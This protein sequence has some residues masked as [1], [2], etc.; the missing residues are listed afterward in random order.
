M[1]RRHK[2]SEMIIKAR[3]SAYQHSIV[4]HDIVTY[5]LVQWRS[6][7]NTCVGDGTIAHHLKGYIVRI[8]SRTIRHDHAQTEEDEWEKHDQQYAPGQ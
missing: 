4:E 1:E 7:S 2:P 5:G 3:H 6:V 8:G